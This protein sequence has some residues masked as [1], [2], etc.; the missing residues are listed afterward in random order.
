MC[1]LFSP[2]SPSLSM[3]LLNLGPCCFFIYCFLSYFSVEMHLLLFSPSAWSIIF[4]HALPASLAAVV[5]NWC[6]SV[7]AFILCLL[8][9]PSLLS[10][11]LSLPHVSYLPHSVSA[12]RDGYQTD[13]Q[14]ASAHWTHFSAGSLTLHFF[15]VQL[16]SRRLFLDES[17]CCRCAQGQDTALPCI[18]FAIHPQTFLIATCTICYPG[19]YFFSTSV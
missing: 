16:L 5:S 8:P 14:P 3:A 12:G 11:S 9:P 19:I 4:L 13:C 7:S 18:S 10:S 17:S 1:L 15:I 6:F 2:P